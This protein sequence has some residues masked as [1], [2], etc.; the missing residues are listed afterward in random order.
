[1]REGTLSRSPESCHLLRLIPSAVAAG[2]FP[3]SHALMKP[4]NVYLV[5]SRCVSGTLRGSGISAVPP[6]IR[7]VTLHQRPNQVNGDLHCADLVIGNCLGVVCLEQ[8]SVHCL[9]YVWDSRMSVIMQL[10][11]ACC[12]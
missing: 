7:P 10:P 11:L 2:G 3:L 4:I 12:H 5:R 1:V 8:T 6:P 9:G